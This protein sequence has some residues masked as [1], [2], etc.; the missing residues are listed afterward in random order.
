MPVLFDFLFYLLLIS[1][2]LGPDQVGLLCYSNALL[3]SVIVAQGSEVTK[4]SFK[5]EFAPIHFA[6]PGVLLLDGGLYRVSHL[7]HQGL[8]S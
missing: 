6:G 1:T 3:T 5:G 7:K 8:S 2:F 4:I